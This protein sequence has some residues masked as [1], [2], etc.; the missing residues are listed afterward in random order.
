VLG[1]EI[2]LLQTLTQGAQAPQ[3]GASNEQETSYESA[4]PL[5]TQQAE[6]SRSPDCAWSVSDAAVCACHHHLQVGQA[7]THNQWTL[8]EEQKKNRS[9]MKH[10]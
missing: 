9:Q 7:Q 4:H 5:P 3:A 1:K 6:K 8:Q 2:A 10:V